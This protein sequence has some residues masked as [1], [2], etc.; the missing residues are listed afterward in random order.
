MNN[1]ESQG[2]QGSTA[3]PRES[4]GCGSPFHGPYLKPIEAG[5]G[6]ATSLPP[7][8]HYSRQVMVRSKESDFATIENAASDERLSTFIRGIALP[9]L[10]RRRP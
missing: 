6:R 2:S 3:K 10:G 9:Y 8:T 7:H 1:G 5:V 4:A